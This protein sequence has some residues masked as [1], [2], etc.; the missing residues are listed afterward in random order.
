ML[1]PVLATIVLV[2]FVAAPVTAAGAA[3]APSLDDVPAPNLA[4]A[5]ASIR[6]QLEEAHESARA[7]FRAS[8]PAAAA[9]RASAVGLLGR[10]YMLYGYLDAAQ[11]AV[12][13]A[14]DLDPGDPRWHY[15]L[16]VVLQQNRRYDAADASFEAVLARVPGDPPT[17]IRRAQ[18]ALEQQRTDAAQALFS[19][20]LAEDPEL[21]IAHHGL[22]QVAESRGD[23]AA[24]AG[25]YEKALALQPAATAVHYP[26]ALA[27]RQLGDVDKAR[28]Q[29][30]ARGSVQ[31]AFADPLIEALSAENAGN[32]ALVVAGNH[33]M[34]RG[35]Y[36]AAT[37]AY[38]AAVARAPAEART[39]LMLASALS[40]AG[41]TDAAIAAYRQALAAT[42]EPQPVSHYNLGNLL[43]EKG[44]LDAAIDAF[45][46]ALAQAPDYASALVNLAGALE[47]K[48]ELEAASS[49]AA[50]A[51]ALLPE[52]ES[53][54]L[55]EARLLA[56]RGELVPARGRIESILERRP[57][58][59]D[60]LLALA[61][62]AARAGDASGATE[63][64][65]AATAAAPGRGDL[66]E[67]L[68]AAYG[69]AGRLREAAA[70]YRRA[71]SLV[72]E[73]VGA[74]FGLAMSLILAGE[75]AQAAAA[76]EAGVTS[77]PDALPLRH[78]LARLLATSAVDEIRDG[79]RALELAQG[80]FRAQPSID[81]A[82]TMGMALAEL[83][84]FE[85]A[86]ALQQQIIDRA[87][88]SGQVERLDA[89][90][91]L[92]SRYQRGE[93]V[94]DRRGLDG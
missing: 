26:L 83:G 22:A 25:H 1:R 33:A 92:L 85:E 42:T 2:A 47:A 49:H 45:R 41:E 91:A 50:R 39:R 61:T 60:A 93:P 57:A 79:A 56:R 38:G 51:A 4:D 88:G 78:A 48:G 90:R 12:R 6:A 80:V 31:V 89:L 11:A 68:A 46:Q 70:Q 66:A 40:L 54:L 23:Y 37:E 62:L 72:P 81:H 82:E 87:L 21:A 67:Q 53:V 59:V 20:L 8:P 74:R 24:A 71:I 3:A 34:A 28:A 52:D 7:V 14:R 73:D 63:H 76:L 43:L 44:D 10:L 77:L 30:A 18:I 19:A 29:L 86:G 32:A 94:R 36:R 27:Y 84:R 65:E 17:R 69:R 64:L 9:V 15:F 55:L 58:S 5:D 35:N 16:G 75:H 13:A